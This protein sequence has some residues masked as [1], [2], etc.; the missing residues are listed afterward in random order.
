MGATQG[1]QRHIEN[2]EEA[3]ETGRKMPDIEVCDME[4]ASTRHD[5]ANASSYASEQEVGEEKR[6]NSIFNDVYEIL[7]ELGQGKS[8][9]VYLAREIN[10]PHKLFALKLVRADYLRTGEE[11]VSLIESEITLLNGLNHKNINRL[12]AYGSDGKVQKPS[13]RVIPNLV[14]MLLEYVP[15]NFFDVCQTSG[16]MGE[17]AARF[18]M[19]QIVQAV[20]YLHNEKQAV[21]RD[22]KLENIL[23]DEELNVKVADFGLGA[24]KNISSLTEHHGTKTYMA[25]EIKQGKRYDGRQVD[26]FSLGVIMFIA[27]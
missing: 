26:I 9:R 13:G 11:A 18:F 19:R 27:A 17:D 21:H 24:Y 22:L 6:K 8:S 1:N 7:S 20:K 5:S 25:P 14:Y 10:H 16:A 23:V 2:I 3:Q 12:I 4:S 15:H